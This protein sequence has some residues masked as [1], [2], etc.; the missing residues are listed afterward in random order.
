MKL[1]LNRYIIIV[2]VIVL[3]LLTIFFIDYYYL[4]NYN[5]INLDMKLLK[6]SLSHLFGTDSMGR[7][8]LV[9]TFL[10]FLKSVLIVMGC[11]SIALP[12]GILLGMTAGYFTGIRSILIN[13]ITNVISAVPPLFLLVLVYLAARNSAFIMYFAFIIIILPPVIIRI[14]N[15]VKIVKNYDYI[16]SIKR[17]GVKDK[18]ILFKYILPAIGKQI[19]YLFSDSAVKIVVLDTVMNYLGFVID[20]A[21][22]TFGKIFYEEENIFLAGNSSNWFALFFPILFLIFLV[23]SINKITF[24]LE[25]I[26]NKRFGSNYDYD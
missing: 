11:V 20:S 10:A 9:Q 23:W 22:P 2:S 24:F 12:A 4:N 13:I 25:N 17:I 18:K 8:V 3:F 6:P 5:R 15:E 21:F 19:I 14:S 1:R 26:Y 7:D 16:I